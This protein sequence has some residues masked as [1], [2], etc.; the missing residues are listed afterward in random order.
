MLQDFNKQ[1]PTSIMVVR[2]LTKQA[3]NSRTKI[4][5]SS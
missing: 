3:Q 1:S 2:Q 4:L 5:L